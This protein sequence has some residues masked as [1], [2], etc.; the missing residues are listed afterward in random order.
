MADTKPQRIKTIT[1]LHRLRGFPP[2]E[3]P[4]I[5]VVNFDELQ[6]LN[7]EAPVTRILDFY[8]ISLKRNAH[9]KIK[10]GQQAYDFDE[11][12]MFF[13]APGQ[14]FSVEINKEAPSNTSGWGLLVHPD[15]FWN[16][17]MA[18][19]IKQ[20]EFFDYA[21]H[22]ALFVS[23][24][25]EAMIVGI[26]Q[27]IQR[28]YRSNTDK[29]SDGVIIAQLELLLVYA[30]R[31][32]ERQFMTRKITNHS[33]LSRLE[34][35]LTDYFNDPGLISK[36]IPSVQSVADTLNISPSYLTRLLKILTGQSTEQHIHDKLIEKAKEKLTGTDLSVSEIAYELGFGH[37]QSFSKLFKAKINLSPQAFRQSF[38]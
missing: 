13:M 3:H 38:S 18:K 22:E 1:E 7:D 26:M 12:V 11:G 9:A 33:I 28:E 29:F 15:F 36:G 10:Y 16:T 32:Y 2:P 27:N 6:E 8:S 14:S 35:I 34:E 24:N 31:F 30:G 20:H 19:T 23:A 5:T 4:L 37:P 17:T 25:E 21:V